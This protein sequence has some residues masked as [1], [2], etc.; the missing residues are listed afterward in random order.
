MRSLFLCLFLIFRL[1][2]SIFDWFHPISERAKRAQHAMVGFDL[3][4][5]KAIQDYQIPGT[6]VGVVVDGHVIY[7]KGFGYKDLEKKSP[8]TPDT[9]FA[10][11]SCTKAFAAFS[12]ANLVDEGSLYW[13]QKVIDIFPEFRLFD[14]Y[15]TQHLTIRDLLTHRTGMPR[16]DFMWYNSDFTRGEVIKKLK[17][18]EP[19][20]NLRE[21]YQ[22]NNLMYLV[23]G[24]V[25]EHITEKS[26]EEFVRERILQRL[27]MTH[28]NFS[29]IEMQK[30][31]DFSYPYTLVNGKFEKMT[32]RDISLIGPAGSMNSTLHD[33]THWVQM[34]LN[35]GIYQGAS[36]INP[37]LLQEM[38]TPQVII[39]GAPET[40]ES[41]I[42]SYG[43]GWG[44]TSYRGQYLMSH[45]GVSDG[46]TS[47]IALLPQQGIGV[48]ILCNRNFSSFP[49][50]LSLQLMDRVLELPFID[51]IGQG[52]EGIEKSQLTQNENQV[53]EN[54]LRKQGTSPSHPL[55]SFVGIYEHPGYGIVDVRLMNGKLSA[56]HH[57]ITSV[58]DHWHFNVFTVVEEDQHTF[59]PR[60]G[61][62][63]TFH[64][65][66]KGDIDELTIPYEP[67]VKD[68]VFVRR[69]QE[70][71]PHGEYFRKFIGL[72]E[73]YGYTV[74]I[75]MR[76]HILYAIIPGQ[77]I[78]ELIPGAENEF[79]VKSMSG[80][81]IRFILNK[82]GK[83]EEALLVQPYGAFTAKPKK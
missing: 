44:I 77:P 60:I 43:M 83:V 82:D 3:L 19:S 49:R 75:A 52:L 23:A 79:T 9:Q 8:V 76:N 59:F 10:I 15:A 26:W 70:H 37:S 68:I 18:L 35:E 32:F 45:D 72:Y 73:I 74:E 13:D 63:M 2:A 41:C 36:L 20:S 80:Y 53:K 6:A 46:F 47:T 28:T 67:N 34:Q 33:L 58:L 30:S 4:I 81:N 24:C 54:L 62:M 27:D 69:K 25:L 17:H 11:G 51:W 64:T 39:P 14:L 16:H 78:Y 29:V 38:H 65:N 48:I 57:G 5:E 21:R 61:T 71:L 50:F 31:S 55:E 40:T 22:Y 56:V 12:I 66:L 42:S 7:A 1:H